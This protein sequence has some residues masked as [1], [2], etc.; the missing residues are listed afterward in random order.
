MYLLDSDTCIDVLRGQDRVT[1]R[2]SQVDPGNIYLSAITTFELMHGAVKSSNPTLSLERLHRFFVQVNE[3]AFD[4]EA[5][6]AAA[7][8]QKNLLARRS[9]IGPYDL[10]IAGHAS[11]RGLILVT[12]NAR[13]FQRVQGLTIQSWRT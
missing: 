6:E 3:L 10:L 2:L 7:H 1:E 12:S 4:H 5:A 9:P 11:S 13:E 8:I